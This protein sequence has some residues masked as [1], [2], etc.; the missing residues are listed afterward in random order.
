MKKIAISIFLFQILFAPFVSAQLLQMDLTIFGMDCAICAHGVRTGLLKIEG[1]QKVD[2]SLEK[3]STH[4]EF[5]PDNKVLLTQIENAVK[6]NGF[7]P[8]G[9]N[10]EFKG[11]IQNSEVIVTGSNE[12]VPSTIPKSGTTDPQKEYVMH[13]I[14]KIDDKGSQSLSI[15]SAN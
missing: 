4:I 2:V 8:K 5:K 10:I 13:G 9:G 11:R 6:R 3:G 14:L 15:T 7:S 12:T 1:V